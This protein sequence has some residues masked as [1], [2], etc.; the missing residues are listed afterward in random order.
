MPKVQSRQTPYGW[1][2]R[3]KCDCGADVRLETDIKMTRLCR[4]FDCQFHDL[5][6]LKEI[7]E[8]DSGEKRKPEKT[9]KGKKR[10]R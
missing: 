5:E 1:E 8:E 9:Y 3:Y 6:L 7:L 4:C 2:Y 10:I